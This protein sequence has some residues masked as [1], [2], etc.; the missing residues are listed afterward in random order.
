MSLPAAADLHTSGS[1]F[2]PAFVE[3]A[4]KAGYKP[5][6]MTHAEA[7][8]LRLTISGICEASHEGLPG[9]Q[10]EDGDY[11]D[12]DDR[13]GIL[14]LDSCG[15][16]ALSI[17]ADNLHRDLSQGYGHRT[18]GGNKPMTLADAIGA[19]AAGA[20][21]IDIEVDGEVDGCWRILRR[22]VARS[23]HVMSL[24]MWPLDLE[25]RFISSTA[26]LAIHDAVEDNSSV[27]TSIPTRKE[28][29]AEARAEWEAK[30]Y[31]TTLRGF[32]ER[33]ADIAR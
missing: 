9:G 2:H 4:S 19:V 16:V 7:V 32:V 21:V 23:L 31:R 6:H 33:L 5:L 17:V 25:S 22:D 3:A 13:P 10:S 14:Q 12:C 11:P 28:A 15:R 8:L 24:L 29:E 18:M 30:G 20:T 26:S 27:E 1:R